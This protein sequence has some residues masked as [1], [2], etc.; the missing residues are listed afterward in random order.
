MKP[1]VEIKPLNLPFGEERPPTS[2]ELLMKSLLDYNTL[3]TSWK[4]V[5]PQ[6]VVGGRRGM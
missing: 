6:G 3:K 4:N 1:V 2:E 5:G